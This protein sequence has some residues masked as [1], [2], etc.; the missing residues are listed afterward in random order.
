[1]SST[2][3][4][5]FLFGSFERLVSRV[6]VC[7]LR[8]SLTGSSLKRPSWVPHGPPDCI[9]PPHKCSGFTALAKKPK[10]TPTCENPFRPIVKVVLESGACLFGTIPRV[11]TTKSKNDRRNEIHLFRLPLL[12]KMEHIL[13]TISFKRDARTCVRNTH[14]NSLD[15]TPLNLSRDTAA[16]NAA[17]SHPQMPKLSITHDVV[18]PL[19]VVGGSSA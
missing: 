13:F 7:A 8:N 11:T 16:S 1:M 17:P 6:V 3:T 19:F 10:G 15:G 12:R 2:S 18:A 9:V 4:L 14:S 5:S